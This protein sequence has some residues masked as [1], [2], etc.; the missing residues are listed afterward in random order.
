[1]A[2][3]QKGESGNPQGRP[4]GIINQATLRASIEKDVPAIIKALT[5]Q[6][7]SGDVGACKLLLDRV[8]PAL[9]PQDTTIQLPMGDDLAANGRAI[10]AATGNADITPEQASKLLQGLGSLARVLETGELLARIESLE[11]A[12]AATQKPS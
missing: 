4:K 7:T 12:H 6:A 9:K 1:M 8:L 3:Y 11:Q 10:L 2:K 5:E